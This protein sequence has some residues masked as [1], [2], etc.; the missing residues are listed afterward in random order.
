[1]PDLPIDTLLIIGLVIA[2]FVGKIFQKKRS[3]GTDT[4]PNSKTNTDKQNQ[5]SLGDILKEAWERANNPPEKLETE[6]AEEII[7]PALPNK[8]LDVNI[9]ENEEFNEVEQ[10]KSS[11]PLPYHIS[12]LAEEANEQKQP[13]SKKDLI[14]GPDSLKKAFLLKE[15]LDEP[16]S[17]RTFPL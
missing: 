14:S 10:M 6:L 2:S 12:S 9:V 15:I 1:M 13:W 17:L 4:N 5:P 8:S 16:K 11:Q 3:E 7:P